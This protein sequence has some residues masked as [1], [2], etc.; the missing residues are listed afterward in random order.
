MFVAVRAFSFFPF[1]SYCF[2]NGP[3][4]F[5]LQPHALDDDRRAIVAIG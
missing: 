1:S 2:P 4:W 5:S 3:T